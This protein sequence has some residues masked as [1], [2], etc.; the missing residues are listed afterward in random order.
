MSLP[1]SI[2]LLF[3]GGVYV[4]IAHIII[5]VCR[6]NIKDFVCMNVCCFVEFQSFSFSVGKTYLKYTHQ[7]LQSI[8]EH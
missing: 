1:F 6:F 7:L 2:L 8:T 4:V 5:I 3:I